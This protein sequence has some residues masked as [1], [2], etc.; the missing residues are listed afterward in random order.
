[1]I[2][3]N[4]LLFLQIGTW[5]ICHHRFHTATDGIRY[6]DPLP[7][8]IVSAGESWRRGKEGLQC[9]QRSRMPQ[10]NPEN[11]LTWAPRDSE[12]EL[13]SSE[14]GTY[15]GLLNLY[16]LVVLQNS[17][18]WVQGLSLCP[19]LAFQTTLFLLVTLSRQCKGTMVS[20]FTAV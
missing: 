17:L 5:V 15:L 12:N 10:V 13:T 20:S 6:R 4:I 7:K 11:H 18:Q 16:C 19:L 1:M 14:D 3:D 2:P 8:L 9:A